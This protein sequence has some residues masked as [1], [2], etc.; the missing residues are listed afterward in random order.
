MGGSSH[1]RIFRNYVH[2]PY[3]LMALAEYCIVVACVYFAVYSELWMLPSENRSVMASSLIYALVVVISMISMGVYESRIREG[4]SGMLLR[5]AVAIFLIATMGIAVIAYFIPLISLGR[6][7]LTIC[8][9]FAFLSTTLFRWI[10]ISI[11]D[12]DSLK[13]CVLILGTENQ[14]QKISLRM[15]REYDRRGFVLLGFLQMKGSSN[16]LDP[17]QRVFSIE[18]SLVDYCLQQNVDEIVVALDERRR[19]TQSAGS[20]LP[21]DDLFECRLK[22]I[23]VCDVQG[24]IEREAGKLDIELLRPSWMVFSEGFIHNT[25]RAQ[26][27]R[28]FDLLA[29]I[30]LLTVSWPIML[31]TGLMLWVGSGFSKPVFYR[32]V[33]V[34]KNGVNFNLFK[35]R[36]MNIDA[37]KD[38]KVQWTAENDPR[39]TRIGNFLRRTR[40]DELPQI[41]NILKGDMSFVGP[42]PE[43]PEFVARLCEDIDYYA[44]RH[45]LKPG[46]TG[47]A[48]LCYPYG[49]SVEDS[50]EKLQYDLYYIK[51][52]NLLL[53]LIILLQTVQV[54]LVGQG[55]R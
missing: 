51:N 14:A 10:V 7:V 38:G 2:T 52:Q 16:L 44:H 50:K 55:V 5:T 36:S 18:G 12:K 46:L 6:G 24:F 21:L 8:T 53:D 34:G 49:G 30:M 35:F 45:H 20:G 31:I 25:F 26:T 54:V 11:T 28:G 15:R 9:V 22:G 3:L 4:F 27:K 23:N 47:W 29:S 37:E 33:R 42:R 32:Q 39:I 48:Q 19:S 17:A 43:R 41:L 13:K 40:I 1:I